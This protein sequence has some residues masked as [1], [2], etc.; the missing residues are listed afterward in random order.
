[1]FLIRPKITI[2]Y[3]VLFLSTK[4]KVLCMQMAPSEEQLDGLHAN[5]FDVDMSG[6]YV[7][8]PNGYCDLDIKVFRDCVLISS[9]DQAVLVR[10]IQSPMG[11][12]R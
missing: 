2:S 3:D 1:M 4:K 11:N 7:Y 8:L 9:A 10:M 6:I 5:M 12:V